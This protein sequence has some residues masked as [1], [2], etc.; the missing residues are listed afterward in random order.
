MN[1]FRSEE[2]AR[3]WPEFKPYTVENLKPLSF[4]LERFSNEMMRSRARPDFI[5]WYTAWRLAR[6]QA[7]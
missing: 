6:P 4:W 3:R 7:K 5:S 1:L 2:H